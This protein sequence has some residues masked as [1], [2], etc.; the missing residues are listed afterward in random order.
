MAV[1]TYTEGGAGRMGTGSG[2]G[3]W[4][5]HNQTIGNSCTWQYIMITTYQ[6]SNTCD[7]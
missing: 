2:R 1:G 5:Y 6:Y 7:F 3:L 4:Q